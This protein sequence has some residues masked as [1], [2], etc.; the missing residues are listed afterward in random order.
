MTFKEK[1]LAFQIYI[2]I[3]FFIGLVIFP[4]SATLPTII[5]SQIIYAG[6]CGTVFYHRVSAH[7]NQ[8]NP[9]VE[10][11][12]I[13]LSWIGI[14]SSA[15]S[16]AGVHRKHH[17]FSD[18]IKDPHSPKFIGKFKTY[19][20]LSNNDQ[21]ALKYVPD[22]M[23]KQWYVFQH[24]HYFKVLLMLHITVVLLL[25]IQ[26][27]WGVLIVPAFLMW[28]SGSII[29]MFCHDNHGPKNIDTIG[30]L[31]AGEGWHKNHHLDPS[32]PSFGHRADWGNV[33]YNLIKLK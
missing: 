6:I 15:I 22:L 27:Y 13:C 25:P 1:L 33:L 26:W 28:C 29:N 24:K 3:L 14:T 16:W 12:L 23:K 32:N 8:I 30:V 19:W 4:I 21:D 5:I 10:K 9:F 31:T 2:H 7:K 11:F 20:Q 18:T 17:R